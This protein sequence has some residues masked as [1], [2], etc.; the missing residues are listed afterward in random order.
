LRSKLKTIIVML[1]ASGG[2]MLAGTGLLDRAGH[3]IGLGQSE[4][5][6]H[7]YLDDAYERALEGFLV[8]SVVKSGLAVIESNVI[9]N[10]CRLSVRP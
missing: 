4:R 8:P 2:I 5:A 6:N 10:D 1:M 7:G 3:R 9:T